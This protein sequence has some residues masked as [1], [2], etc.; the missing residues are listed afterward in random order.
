MIDLDPQGRSSIAD[1]MSML[2]DEILDSS[3]EPEVAFRDGRRWVPRITRT[4]PTPQSV[5]VRSDGAYIVTGGLGALGLRVAE[6]LGSQGARHLVLVSRSAAVPE[7]VRQRIAA[8]ESTG[9]KVSIAKVDVADLDGLRETIAQSCGGSSIR[10]VVHAAGIGGYRD[11]AQMSLSDISAVLHPKVAGAWN[12]HEITQHLDIDFFNCFSS[13]ASAW[14]SRG[15]AHYAAANSFLDSLAL[16]R[17]GLGLTSLTVNWGPWSGGGMTNP[18]A[19]KLLKRV[20]VKTLNPQDSLKCF[21]FL[22]SRDL[23]RVIVADVEWDLFAGSYEAKGRRPLLDRVRERTGPATSAKSANLAHL[24]MMEVD[25]RRRWMTALIQQEAAEVLGLQSA[26]E[27]GP[28]VGLFELGMDSLM[29]LEFRGRLESAVGRSLPATLA[30]D[31]PSAA[32]IAEFILCDVLSFDKARRDSQLSQI[33]KLK[34]ATHEAI[35]IIGVGC[36]F[37]GGADGPEAFWRLLKDGVDAITEVPAER[38][39]IGDYYDSDPE[40]PGKMYCRHGGFLRDVDRFD[41][42]FFRVAPREA[43]SMDPQQRIA[44]EV[45]WEALEH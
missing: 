44:L 20:G 31:Y 42:S 35:A 23:A 9:I 40:K 5:Q 1:E 14:G 26:V 39:N 6:W 12:L 15:Q 45:S 28:N 36:R 2:L 17:R 43:A 37:P 7:P 34:P 21:S 16:Y 41:A 32:A 27:V 30:F 8:M 13:I 4:L 3:S 22:G 10:G 18:E 33:G 19:G 11:I 29:A 38:W 25:E 24:E